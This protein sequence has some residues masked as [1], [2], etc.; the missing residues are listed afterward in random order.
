MS[1]QRIG[2]LRVAMARKGGG[3]GSAPP[4]VPTLTAPSNGATITNGTPVT[5]SAATTDVNLTSMSWVLDGV[6]VV[7]TVLGVGTP[8][9]T[10]STSWTPTGVSNGAH[11]LVA[12]ATRGATSDSSSI[13]LTASSGGGG[14]TTNVVAVGATAPTATA[15]NDSNNK[16]QVGA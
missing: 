3:S 9:G 8:A 15:I 2:Q 5:V 14:N 7:A 11:T 12:R 16:I 10:F 1:G 4:A 6:T 13:S